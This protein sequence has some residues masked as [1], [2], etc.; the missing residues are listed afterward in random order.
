LIGGVEA[1]DA[2]AAIEKAAQEFKIEAEK[3]IAAR[4]R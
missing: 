4:R 3:L 2:D 1:T